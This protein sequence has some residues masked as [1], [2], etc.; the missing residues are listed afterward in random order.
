MTHPQWPSRLGQAVAAEV[1]R[2][3]Q[4]Q[5]L[6]AQQLADRCAALGLPLGRSVLANFESGR[7]PTVSVPELLVLAKALGVPPIALLYPVGH[8]DRVEALP[9]RAAPTWEALRWFTGE[10][11]LPTEQPEG[12]ARPWAVSPADAEE[13]QED[14]AGLTDYRWH[15][16]YLEEWRADRAAAAR[17]TTDGARDA[18]LQQ[19]AG[20]EG[21]LWDARR[22]LR[23][24]GVRLPDLP[25]ELEH[26]NADDYQPDWGNLR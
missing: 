11:P 15:D 12:A 5:G 13:W 3:R 19:A 21:P 22:R 1:R 7:R 17:A 9:D 23:A 26:I 14:R 6:S 10:G 18:L 24:L 2:H 20:R 4:A 16:R 25:A 8:E